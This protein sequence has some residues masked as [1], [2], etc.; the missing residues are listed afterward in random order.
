MTAGLLYPALLNAYNE[1]FGPIVPVQ[2]WSNE[3]EVIRRANAT[4]TGLGACVW[5]NDLERAE[6]IA[7]QIE[8]G[9]V[10]INSFEKPHPAGFFSGYKES[11]LGGGIWR[12]GDERVLH[13]SNLPLC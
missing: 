12:V 6:R 3:D 1:A 5:S 13:H 8:A 9:S 11:G 10:W 2:P 4:L 7:Q